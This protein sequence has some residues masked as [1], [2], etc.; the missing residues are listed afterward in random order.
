MGISLFLIIVLLLVLGAE[1]VNG[2]TDAPNAIVTVVGTR[3]LSLRKAIIIATVGNA[4]GI[5]ISM[6]F[7]VKVAKTIGSGFVHTQYVDLIMVASTMLTIIIWSMFTFI[8]DGLPTSESH[9]LVAAISGAGFATAGIQAL[10]LS[11]W[12]SGIAKVGY[13]LLCSSVIG[14]FG[15]YLLTKV[16]I[17]FMRFINVRQ[18]RSWFST[19]QKITALF[20][21]ISHGYGDGQ[22]FIGIFVLALFSE[23]IIPEFAVPV[24]VCVLC[25]GV[26]ALG[27]SLGGWKI[28]KTMGRQLVDLQRFQ[29]VASELWASFTIMTA[30]SF[31]IPLS[32]THTIG[33]SIMGAGYAQRKSALN[34]T[35]AK[36]IIWAWVLTFPACWILSYL[37][38]T[39]MRL[40]L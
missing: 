33:T 20:M 23:K 7:G 3:V 10:V 17:F 5:F 15:S 6:Y 35:K 19:M 2:W 37:I 11:G 34:K 30:G 21:G 36:R 4:A 1:F 8:Y 13:G 12:D 27:T 9:A 29:G 39:F 38:T 40:I 24:W 31:G 14:F 32:T 22:K 18:E 26:M 28:I 16:I 25:A